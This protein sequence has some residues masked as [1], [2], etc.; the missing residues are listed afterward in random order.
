[1]NV[2]GFSSIGLGLRFAKRSNRLQTQ[3]HINLAE[4]GVTTFLIGQAGRYRRAIV[5]EM[6]Q[7]LHCVVFVR[8]ID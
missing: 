1:M 2:C 4:E 8:N 6:L 3:I 7:N 5:T